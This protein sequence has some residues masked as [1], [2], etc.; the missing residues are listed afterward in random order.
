MYKI[1]IVDDDPSILRMLA[2]LLKAQLD[3]R[4]DTVESGEQALVQL[5]SIDYDLI[6]LDINLPQRSGLEI[7]KILSNQ[8]P[9]LPVVIMTAHSKPQVIIDA[10]KEG[11]YEFLS[12]PFET[13]ELLDIIKRLLKSQELTRT[14]HQI[15]SLSLKSGETFI[16]GK[17]PKMIE[18][19]KRIG[20][21][22]SSDATV[23]ILG[24][25]GTGKELVARAIYQNSLR[26]DRAYLAVNCAAIP[27]T[28]LESELFGYEKGAFT[29]ATAR[30]LGKFEQCNHGTIFLDEIGDMPLSTQA[31]ILRVLQEGQFERLGGSS[32]IQVDVRI[33]AATNQDIRQLI[34]EKRFRQDLYYRL[35]VFTITIP[36]LRE[37]REDIRLLAEHFLARFINRDGKAIA[38]FAPEAMELLQDHRWQGNVRELQNTIERAVVICRD[39][40]IMPEHIQLQAELKGDAGKTQA[41]AQDAQSESVFDIEQLASEELTLE[42]VEE[43]YIRLILKK[44]NWRLNETASALGIHRNTLR[45]KMEQYRIS[46]DR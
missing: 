28:L 27:E 44:Y 5:E 4:I 29:G 39:Q 38:G 19:F 46:K 14:P 12:K 13:Q 30:K 24:E 10:I 22:A 8:K 34:S 20:Q 26:K 40:V 3:A 18:V 9:H 45:R 7:L 1:L 32:T 35:S 16:I 42:Q 6:L 23:L 15:I 33:I 17:N 31:K 36:P 41:S 21:V 11:A 43:R 2:R 37:R 25:S